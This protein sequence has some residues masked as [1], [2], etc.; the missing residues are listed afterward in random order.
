[1]ENYPRLR[2]AVSGAR[3][4]AEQDSQGCVVVCTHSGDFLSPNPL[5][6]LDMG[7]SFVEGL[8]SIP[9]DFIC[10]GN[11]E[12]DIPNPTLQQRV[13]EFAGTWLNANILDPSFVDSSNQTLQPYK[14]VD[15]GC[16]KVA[17]A[18]F[19]TGQQDIYRPGTLRKVVPIID[20]VFQTWDKAAAEGA[21]VMVPLTHQLMHEDRELVRAL[22]SNPCT[23]GRMP[24]ILGGHDHDLYEVHEDECTILKVGEDAVNLAVVDIWWTR[25]GS[26]RSSYQLVQAC[27]FQPDPKTA[28]LVKKKEAMLESMKHVNICSMDT[29]MSSKGVRRKPEGIASM[30]CSKIKHSL[31]K[32]D[33]CLLQGGAVRGRADYRPGPFTYGDLVNEL[34]FPT[35]MATIHLPGHVIAE[36]VKRSRS[37]PD[38]EHPTFLHH[39][40][41]TV[42]EPFP[43]LQCVTINKQ[44]FQPEKMYTV[45]IY[46]VLVV[47]MNEVQPMLSYIQDSGMTVPSIDDTI[48]AKQLV[49]EACMREQWLRL[50]AEIRVLP[51]SRHASQD[52]I[53]ERLFSQLDK[54]R[55]GWVSKQELAEYLSKRDCALT[56]RPCEQ[57]LTWLISTLDTDQDG[58]ISK[59]DLRSL[60][61]EA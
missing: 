26:M 21:E 31:P 40:T 53:V 22:Q 1:M 6:S 61:I 44:P 19:C 30:L 50:A 17:V 7:K 52:G 49:V 58:Y 18:G 10:F 15:V 4:A 27:N 34:A 12:F 55:D 2:T 39:D 59:Q 23:R 8:N 41:D 37:D 24:F 28:A 57:L 45:T 3:A 51:A 42:F 32:V 25:E 60:M 5:T 13:R 46:H 36:S 35:E 48:P 54:N 9:V 47:G 29:P 20:S 56:Q 16:H 38:V 14:I 33:I 11:H 43:S